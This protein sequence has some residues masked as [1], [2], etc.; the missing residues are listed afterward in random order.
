[1]D[2][3]VFSG[4]VMAIQRLIETEIGASTDR[5]IGGSQLARLGR[6]PIKDDSGKMVAVG[7]F[8]LV[9]H[10]GNPIPEKL[11]EFTEALVNDFGNSLIRAS[12]WKKVEQEYMALGIG[13]VLD[14]F[15]QSVTNTKKKGPK[16]PSN[17]S[18]ITDGVKEAARLLFDNY[19]YSEALKALAS[20]SSEQLKSLRKSKREREEF[21][22]HF[23]RDCLVLVL[24]QNPVALISYSAPQKV[25]ESAK[26]AIQ[27]DIGSLQKESRDRINRIAI[28]IMENRIQ[29]ILD[30]FPL[31]ELNNTQ[32]IAE[33]RDQI[34]LELSSDLLSSHPLSFLIDSNIEKT[35][36]EAASKLVDDIL[37]EWD[38]SSICVKLADGFLEKEPE[39]SRKMINGL[40]ESFTL[41]F[42]RGMD[43]IAW[44]MMR[45][46]QELL[47]ESTN[48]N[49]EDSVKKISQE[50][51]PNH[52]EVI[53]NGL[54]SKKKKSKEIKFTIRSGDEVIETFEA[55]NGT[56]LQGL[57]NY[58][59]YLLLGSETSKYNCGELFLEW[60]RELI[61]I[62]KRAHDVYSCTRI[63]SEIIS[64][65]STDFPTIYLLPTLKELETIS[66]S[67]GPQAWTDID[68]LKKTIEKIHR[69]YQRRKRKEIEQ[70]GHILKD[71]YLKSLKQV[72]NH[73]E[74]STTRAVK[75]FE[76][77]VPDFS[78][79]E[80]TD[81]FES[82]ISHWKELEGVLDNIQRGTDLFISGKKGEKFAD[83]LRKNALK[84]LPKKH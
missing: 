81:G 57:T 79:I 22:E 36:E 39:S 27:S 28:E 50:L 53:T 12:I 25:I 17:D 77:V 69:D 80:I 37:K 84:R 9:S 68:S 75:G 34:T 26:N 60:G 11:L 38:L 82:F 73:V 23:S 62:A 54:I 8:L 18:L 47:A 56:V 31:D 61:E 66:K 43:D 42:P 32:T 24:A 44:E 6:L 4:G 67:S 45:N 33:L 19:E 70:K 76:T 1:M 21:L 64:K 72:E 46:F 49:L 5:F 20:A 74:L 15:I 78:S 7:Q 30:K 3:T 83:K 59:T 52:Q 48:Q 16:L 14:P 13:E 41:G 2:E 40:I 71:I 29:N 55:L 65:N 63:I 10:S 51:P 58:L 35:L